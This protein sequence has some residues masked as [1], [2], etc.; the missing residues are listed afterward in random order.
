MWRKILISFKFSNE[1]Q[2]AEQIVTWLK[3]KGWEVY[4]EVQIRSYDSIADIVAVKND[5]IWV[6]E[7]KLNF[8]FKVLAQ[9]DG[10]IDYAHYVSIGIPCK[11][12]NL[13]RE[14][15]A[16][17]LGIG[18]LTVRKHN[19][20]EE[21]IIKE[22]TS[23]KECNDPLEILK[24]R[25]NEHQKNFAKA[26]NSYGERYTPYKN[27]LRQLEELVKQEPGIKL[28]DAI[29]K[30]NHHYRTDKNAICSI[31]QWIRNGQIQTLKL[32]KI[33]GVNTL[34]YEK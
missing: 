19:Y 13:F 3:S 30:I 23:P 34:Y 12:T 31:S 26:G 18:V 27:T 17:L 7:T 9:A 29:I 10:W 6:I 32:E 14:R 20:K 1:E 33:K 25:L 5:K 28:K 22:R 11:Y 21:F 4:Q 2:L 24:D 15:I 8:G 16:S